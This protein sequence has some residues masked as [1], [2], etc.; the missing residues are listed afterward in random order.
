VR[1]RPLSP[2]GDFTIGVPFLTNSPAAVGQL[3]STRLKLWVGEWFLDVTDGMPW[4]QDVDG[5]PNNGTPDAALKQRILS[6]AGVL[7][8][9]TYNSTFNGRTRA[10]AASGTIKTQYGEAEFSA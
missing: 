7:S 2:S 4:A 10:F 9:V 6:T 1:Y 5:K 3:V 8:I